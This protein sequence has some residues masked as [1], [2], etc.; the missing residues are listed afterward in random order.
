MTWPIAKLET[1][2]GFIDLVGKIKVQTFI[3][4]GPLAK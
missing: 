4:L 3:F 1:F 2:L